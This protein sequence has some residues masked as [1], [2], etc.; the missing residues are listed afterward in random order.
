MAPFGIVAA[1][2]CAASTVDE[3]LPFV[4]LVLR[5]E[6]VEEGWWEGGAFLTPVG[7]VK[8]YP[9]SQDVRVWRFGCLSLSCL[10]V[11]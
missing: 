10:R 6:M 11:R 5:R 4:A 2:R 9:K 7:E 3:N 1:Q 8:G